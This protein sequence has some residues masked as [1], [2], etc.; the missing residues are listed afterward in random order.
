[1]TPLGLRDGAKTFSRSIDILLKNQF[2][3]CNM[4]DSRSFFDKVAS[5][6]EVI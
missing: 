1:M 5:Y 3:D 4:K 6:I 2:S